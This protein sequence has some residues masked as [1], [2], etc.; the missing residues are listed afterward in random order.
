M[1]IWELFGNSLMFIVACVVVGWVLTMIIEKAYAD[2][3]E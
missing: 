3:E 2:V 1:F